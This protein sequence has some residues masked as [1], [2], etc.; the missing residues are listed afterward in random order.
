MHELS[1][2]QSAIELAEQAAAGRRIK[3][4]TLEIGELAGVTVEALAFCF[5]LA[6]EGTPAEGAT[7]EIRR[8]A[9]LAQCQLCNKRFPASSRLAV[10]DCG[11]SR[12]CF[13]EGEELN[14]KSIELWG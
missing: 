1:I 5:D 14:M 10:C 13:L 12:I 4:V 7:L 2:A 8:V 6:T 11:S 9:G 3:Q